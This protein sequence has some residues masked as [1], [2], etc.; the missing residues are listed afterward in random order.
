MADQNR[1]DEDEDVTKGGIEHVIQQVTT[2]EDVPGEEVKDVYQ[3]QQRI[4]SSDNPQDVL[5]GEAQK[6]SSEK[7]EPL[8]P[9]Q[10]E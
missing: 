10:E 7:P 2:G 5:E 8:P 6:A 1:T 9:A 4:V 3:Y